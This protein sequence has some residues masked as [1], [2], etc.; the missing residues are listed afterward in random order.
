M[1]IYVILISNSN[2]FDNRLDISVSSLSRR[3]H[4]GASY[5]V[6]YLL[7]TRLV[8]MAARLDKTS[9]I[10]ALSCGMSEEQAT[11]ISRMELISFS[12]SF[13]ASSELLV[14]A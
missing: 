12:R 7:P 1:L 9:L 4:V 13:L 2:T 3:E 14:V 5:A 11:P 8:L 6:I 10:L